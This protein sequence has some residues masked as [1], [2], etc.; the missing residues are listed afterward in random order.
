MR[1]IRGRK[2]SGVRIVI[3][4]IK[5]VGAGSRPLTFGGL[6]RYTY[7]LPREV[8]W[9]SVLKNSGGRSLPSKE[10]R[11][12]SIEPGLLGGVGRPGVL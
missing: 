12:Y 3:L 4:I 11:P 10:V 6:S 2:P 5:G 7:C 9:V 1:E 8:I